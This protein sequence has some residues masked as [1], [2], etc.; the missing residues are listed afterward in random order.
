M[1]NAFWDSIMESMKSEGP[2]Y[3]R[4]IQLLKEIRDELCQ[5]APETWRQMIMEAIDLDVLSQV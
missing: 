4:V 2:N 3:D 5:M 1:E